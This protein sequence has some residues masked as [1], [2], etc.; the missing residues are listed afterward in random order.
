ML[1]KIAAASLL[2]ELIDMIGFESTPDEGK[3]DLDTLCMPIH[4]FRDNHDYLERLQ[5]R[6][7]I[8]HEQLGW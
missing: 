7:E 4:V 3:V 5:D 6:C 1:Q 2:S 8:A